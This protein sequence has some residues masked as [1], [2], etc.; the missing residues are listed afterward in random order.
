MLAEIS[1]AT[2][3]VSGLIGKAALNERVM[4]A[5][6][7]VAR[8]EFVSVELQAYAYANLP[9][10]SASTKQSRNHLLSR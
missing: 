1:A 6:G 2:V 7:K 5:M 4:A 10:R 8:H 9:F 3:R